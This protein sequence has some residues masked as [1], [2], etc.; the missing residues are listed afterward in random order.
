MFLGFIRI[1]TGTTK[2]TKVH[3]GFELLSY[4]THEIMNSETQKLRNSKPQNLR[5]SSWLNNKIIAVF[6]QA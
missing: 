3:K 6:C 1:V 5:V 4:L 2:D